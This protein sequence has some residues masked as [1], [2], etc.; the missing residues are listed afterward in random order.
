MS[1]SFGGFNLKA[2]GA[3]IRTDL[4]S[5]QSIVGQ[6]SNIIGITGLAE[7][8]PVN[9]P[10]TITSS[11]EL[12]NTFGSGPLVVHGLAAYV[13]GAS[14]LVAVRLGGAK[15]ASLT[16]LEASPG[17]TEAYE[18]VA[19]ELGTL[20]NNIL[21]SVEADDMGTPGDLED[22]RY[23]IRIKYTD[24]QGN[25][26]RETFSL[27]RYIPDVTGEYYTGNTGDYYLLRDRDTMA[28]SEIPKT[29]TYGNSD[30]DA[31]LSK[32]EDM[33]STSQDLLGPFPHE[34][35]DTSTSTV[36]RSP[37]P[38]ALIASV[39]NY[40][41][42][43]HAPSTLIELDGADPDIDKIMSPGYIYNPETAEKLLPHPYVKLSGGYNGDDGTN[44]FGDYDDLTGIT[45]WKMTHDSSDPAHDGVMD[46]WDDALEV[47]EDEDVNFVQLAY[48]FNNKDDADQWDERYGFFT[49][50]IPK[51]TAHINTMS[52]IPN[53]MFRTSI[54]GTP[55]YKM[56]YTENNTSQDFLDE[57]QEISGLINNDR[58]Q[59]WVGGFSSNAFSNRVM[60]YGGEM[61]ASFVVGA[62]AAREVSVSLTFAQLSGIF[63][64]GLEFSFNTAQRDE[65]YTRRHAF[66]MRRR[67]ASGALEYVAAHNYTSFTGAP[68]RG[69]PLMVTRRIVDY[70]STTVVKNTESTYV[71][72]ASRGAATEAEIRDYITAILSRMVVEDVLVA[73]A[74]VQV[75]A[76]DMD[77]TVYHVSYRM[78]PVT[79]IDF[80][81]VTQHLTY[82]LA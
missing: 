16:A 36:E 38:L 18:W 44:Y 7:K 3:Y 8:G 9:K 50:V 62:Q 58:M 33:K 32:V 60:E 82:Q 19:R 22:D 61:L 78:Q 13:G 57:I 2:F 10:V 77:K 48:L 21:I 27:P 26:I 80:I 63:T 20:G 71:G 59:L 4:S 52:N 76:D 54:V 74:D 49:K 79:E 6:S 72:K 34:Y 24:S 5:L 55:Y 45:D 46:V 1:I 70:V 12:I 30:V 73:Y 28:I 25:D 66:V 69:L 23:F 67:T 37:F 64:H 41:G 39:V 11:S 51:L 29:W 47:L 53:R 81:T 14:T 42:L 40:G 68:N 56:G 75:K 15:G 17:S 31:F 35:M 43:G 65:L